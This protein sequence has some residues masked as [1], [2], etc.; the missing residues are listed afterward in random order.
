MF[1]FQISCMKGRRA[2]SRYWRFSLTSG[3]LNETRVANLHMRRV[4]RVF[5]ANTVTI[6]PHQDGAN[7]GNVAG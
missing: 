5:D 4:L 1:S 3:T 6:A 7:S 2:G